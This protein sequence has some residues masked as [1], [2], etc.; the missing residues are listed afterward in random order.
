MAL[1][2]RWIPFKSRKLLQSLKGFSGIVSS[3]YGKRGQNDRE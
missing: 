2:S 1:Q 3:F